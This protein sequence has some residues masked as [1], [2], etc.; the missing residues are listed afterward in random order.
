VVCRIA[1]HSNYTLYILTL[2]LVVKLNILNIHYL[3]FGLF[4][5]YF[6][7]LDTILLRIYKLRQARSLYFV[8]LCHSTLIHDHFPYQPCIILRPPYQPETQSRFDM[9]RGMTAGMIWKRSCINL[10]IICFRQI[11]L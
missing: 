7:I 4:L 11:V 3:F 1:S 5:H 8:M 10:F 6:D 9:G 2:G